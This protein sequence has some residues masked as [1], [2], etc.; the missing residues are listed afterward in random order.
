MEGNKPGLNNDEKHKFYWIFILIKWL[1]SREWICTEE[2]KTIHGDPQA[3][4]RGCRT[5][6]KHLRQSS[7]QRSR[8]KGWEKSR[9]TS[10][11]WLQLLSQWVQHPQDA[12]EMDHPVCSLPPQFQSQHEKTFRKHPTSQHLLKLSVSSRARTT[13]ETWKW[14][15][16]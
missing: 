11:T 12:V 8:Q 4:G 9:L 13:S 6:L 5:Y 14:G 16:G 7:F 3:Q 10:V 15:V 1:F 2:L